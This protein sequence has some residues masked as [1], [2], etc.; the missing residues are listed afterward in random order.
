MLMQRPEN[1]P[2][3]WAVA[4]GED[5]YGYWQVFEIKGVRQ[6][7]RW[8]PEGEFLMGS[9]EDE[10]Q[11]RGDEMQHE[12]TIHS[13]FWLA[14][15]ACTQALWQV[16]MGTN[17]SDFKESDQNP[18]DSIS[19]EDC[20]VFI[21][22][23]NTL[24]QMDWLSLPTEEQWEYACRAGTTTPFSTGETINTDQANFNGNYPYRDDEKKGLYRDKTVPV[25]TFAPNPWG[26]F[27]MHG[28]LWEW[29]EDIY[30]Q[31]YSGKSV[32]AGEKSSSKRVLRGG[33]WVD[34]MRRLRSA[35]RGGSL[36][37]SSNHSVGLRLAGGFEHQ[38]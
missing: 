33:G 18:V 4:W 8:I 15:T 35:F 29:C 17:P 38:V 37:D 28:N 10:A 23:A 22:K 9:P 14:D 19:W 12:V 36:P 26:L 27:Q 31:D 11:K 25:L 30:E 5:A 2:A 34:R 7:M 20:Q 1:F 13:G 3:L 24:L 32:A 21:Q 6:V 16:V